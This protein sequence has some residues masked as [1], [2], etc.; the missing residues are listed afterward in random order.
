MSQSSLR[1]SFVCIQITAHN[2]RHTFHNRNI[3]IQVFV[4]TN[5][6]GQHNLSL[7]LSCTLQQSNKT[8]N[9]HRCTPIHVP[10]HLYTLGLYLSTPGGGTKTLRN[11][12]CFQ[13]CACTFGWG[14][15]IFK[16]KSRNKKWTVFYLKTLYASNFIEI[17]LNLYVCATRSLFL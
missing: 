3:I 15:S 10:A 6:W 12:I 2:A 9:A 7:S 13:A 14:K 11:S 5:S 4:L 17:M 1:S 8:I 16:K